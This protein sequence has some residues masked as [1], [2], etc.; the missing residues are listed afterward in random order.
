MA[1]TQ[2]ALAA[3][4]SALRATRVAFTTDTSTLA[5]A[6]TNIKQEMR[7]EKSSTN[8]DYTPAQ[9]IELLEQVGAFLRRNIVQGVKRDDSEGRYALN[10]H[11]DT[12]LGDNN[13]I[14]K[15]K[16]R[17]KASGAPPSGGGCCGGGNIELKQKTH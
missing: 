2:R 17:F 11:Q 9:R 1:S 12:E 5:A 15:N 16:S 6:R 10:I 7:A 13:E 4:R 8:P 3:Y 14:K